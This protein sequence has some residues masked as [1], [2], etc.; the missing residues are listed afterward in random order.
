MIDL[1]VLARNLKGMEVV[2]AGGVAVVTARNLAATLGYK[3]EKAVSLI[4]SRHKKV[5]REA[6]IY[7]IEHPSA[8]R[9][10]VDTG[11]IRLETAGGVQ[12]IRVFTIKGALKIC[13]KS[14]Q[15]KSMEVIEMIIDLYDE[16]AKRIGGG[17]Q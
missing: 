14:H 15:P 3:C 2:E 9:G 11:I 16:A 10:P 8:L 7:G 12:D 4:F 5:F 1:P 13:A 6:P 17:A